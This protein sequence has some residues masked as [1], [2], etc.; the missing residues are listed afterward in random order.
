M[1]ARAEVCQRLHEQLTMA[2]QS[3][4]VLDKQTLALSDFRCGIDCGLQGKS[5]S[6]PMAASIQLHETF[7]CGWSRATLHTVFIKATKVQR[8]R[9]PV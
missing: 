7:V 4:G 2:A 6:M 8:K 1:D 5:I 9:T 3:H